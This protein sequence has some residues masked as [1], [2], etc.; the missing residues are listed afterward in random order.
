MASGWEYKRQKKPASRPACKAKNHPHIATKLKARTHYRTEDT[1][2]ITHSILYSVVWY[3]CMYSV[4]V[5]T[6]VTKME[7]GRHP[8]STHNEREIKKHPH[9]STQIRRLDEKPVHL[10][11]N[12]TNQI[13]HSRCKRSSRLFCIYICTCTP[14]IMYCTPNNPNNNNPYH[15]DRSLIDTRVISQSE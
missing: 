11:R 14:Y 8:L 7:V 5:P 10:D 3:V 4:L 12:T 15:L 13:L 2:R 1:L 9:S 6:D